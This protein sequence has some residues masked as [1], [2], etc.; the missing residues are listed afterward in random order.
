M[1]W[2]H[3]NALPS[4]TI[5]SS[6]SAPLH[7]N[8]TNHSNGRLPQLPHGLH[9]HEYRNMRGIQTPLNINHMTNIVPS[10][11]NL[12]Q[13]FTPMRDKATRTTPLRDITNTPHANN[14][15]PQVAV[16]ASL[17]HTSVDPP[18]PQCKEGTVRFIHINTGGISSKKKLV[19]CKLLLTS[20]SQ[21]QADIYSVNEVNL[22]T[23][24]AQ[25]KRDL[26]DIGQTEIR[27]GQQFYSTS[28]ESYPRAF[29][30]G[31]TMLG[32]APHMASRREDHGS[33]SKGRW[34]WVQLTGK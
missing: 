31:G 15:T 20:I 16:R 24:Q 2:Q 32:L 22:N 3:T 11:Q 17:T 26:Y 6:T 10:E 14:T 27:H 18:L 9:A 4:G 5:A 29:K 12:H 7:N 28:K 25:I 21:S 30:P 1:S 33:D 13:F 19:E 34:T 8:S 23:T